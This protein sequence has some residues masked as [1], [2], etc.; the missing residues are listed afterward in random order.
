MNTDTL[1]PVLVF[2]TMMLAG[3]PVSAQSADPFRPT[4]NRRES[5]WIQEAQQKGADDLEQAIAGLKE[6]DLSTASAAV[7][8]TLG[9]LYFQSENH[10]QAAAAYEKALEKFPAFRNAKINLGRIYLILEREAEAIRL[11]QELVRDGVADAE[12][13]LLLGHAL[14]MESF[15]VSAENAY[16]QALLLDQNLREAKRGLLSTLMSQ[17]RHREGLSLAKELLIL[18]PGQ[19]EYWAARANAQL[20]LGETAEAASGLEQARRLGSVDADMLA[21]LGELYLQ[22]QAPAEAAARFEEAFEMGEDRL[23]RRERAIT[24]F[25]QTGAAEEAE[26]LLEGFKTRLDRLSPAEKPE[27]E[28]SYLRLRSRV[29]LEKGDLEEALR[30]GQRILETDPL[31]GGTLLMLAG[32]YEEQGDLEQAVSY[33]ER[34]ARIQGFEADAFI[35]Q[36]LIEAGRQRVERAVQLLERAQTYQENAAVARY[37]R[38]LR[39]ME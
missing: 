4:V 27:W 26:R 16:R 29:D 23:Q 2:L 1:A 34:A 9:N 31:D 32:I 7:D 35:R 38:Q 18:E 30:K 33:C 8:F 14:M 25:L 24:G 22:Q 15:P 21:T 28:L 37:L 20:A 5:E 36:A 6:R 19:R 10:E 13:Y 11:Y 39:R 3:N 17:E 12:T